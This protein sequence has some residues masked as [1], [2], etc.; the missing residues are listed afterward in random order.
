MNDINRNLEEDNDSPIIFI[1]VALVVIVVAS[2]FSVI[3]INHAF[4]PDK[5][6]KTI[7]F[8]RTPHYINLVLDDS[9]SMSEDNKWDKA[10][11]GLKSLTASLE[12]QD[13]LHIWTLNGGKIIDI[14]GND[15]TEENSQK[16][17]D[18]A[19]NKGGTPFIE[20]HNSYE[21]LKD[22]NLPNDV[23]KYLIVFTDGGFNEGPSSDDEMESIRSDESM[24]VIFSLSDFGDEFN[25]II[26]N[27]NSTI[28]NPD[29]NNP[30]SISTH[31]KTCKK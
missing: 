19:F 22:K 26:E 25:E 3:V 15:T 20:V 14:F 4:S 23:E 12:S 29:F 8:P 10:L 7:T 18:I 31:K 17:H 16:I 5:C 11:N 30:D 1:V 24:K 21:E 13:E 2:L 9:G 6:E 27:F 28:S